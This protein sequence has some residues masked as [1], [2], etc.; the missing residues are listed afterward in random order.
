LLGPGLFLMLW[1]VAAT[2][3]VIDP[4]TLAGPLTVVAT[5]ADM[6]E[7][8]QLGQH[9]IVSLARAV[10]G[11]IIGVAVGTCLAVVA[12]LFRLGEDLIDSTMQVL[13][14][15]PVLGMVPLAILWFGIGEEVKVVLVAIGTTFPVYLNTHAGIRG[16]DRRYVELAATLGLS[17]AA[18]VRRVL[19][20]AALPGFFV[21]LRYAVTLEWLILVV[22][23]QIN[24]SSGI[25]Y[26]MIQARAFLRTDVIVVGLAVYGILG[27]VS[28]ALVRL[29]ERRVLRWQ[30]GF[31]GT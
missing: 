19:L 15:L 14:S 27:L 28:N 10:S 20:P 8:G 11:L 30:T 1:Q 6:I 16:V 5:A 25:G 24:A 13:R 22:A 9:L 3:E 23:E 2:T 21:G 4:A 7:S 26:L 17:R 31:E 18:L 12:G 29:L